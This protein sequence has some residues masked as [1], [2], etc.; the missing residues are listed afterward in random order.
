MNLKELAKAVSVSRDGVTI[1][2]RAGVASMMDSLIY[3]AVF[4]E[5]DRKVNLLMLV[6]EI[7]KAC[8]A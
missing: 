4:A 2:D 1:K 3:E 6:K 8:G 7:A 5:G